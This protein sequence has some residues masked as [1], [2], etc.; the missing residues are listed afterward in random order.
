MRFSDAEGFPVTD[1][2]PQEVRVW[3]GS[4]ALE[5]RG[6]LGPSEPFD[7]GLVLDVSPSVEQYVDAIRQETSSFF[8]SLRNRDRGMILTFDS[9]IYV[10]CDWTTDRD[11]IDEAIFEFGLHKR[12]EQSVIFDALAVSLEQKFWKRGPRQILIFM[13]DGVEHGSEETKEQESLEVARRSGLVVYAIQ[14][15]P[16]EHYLRLHRGAAH[17]PTWEPPP[18]TT[19][20]TVG[21]IFVGTGRPSTGDLADYKVGRILE[22]STKYM[23]EV[24]ES[25]RG[26]YHLMRQSFDLQSIY[27]SIL[28]DLSDLTTIT[29]ARP[30]PADGRFLEV[31]I[32]STRPGVTATPLTRGAW[33]NR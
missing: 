23:R 14:Y 2:E 13:S 6:V 22:R 18:G 20:G 30:E 11:E 7:A 31:R 15:D 26:S 24:A 27:R 4:R 5:V 32:E 16:R 8:R 33:A 3:Q 28:E 9:Q 12:G 19:G 10:D 29:I 21:G 1:L 17:D 25:G